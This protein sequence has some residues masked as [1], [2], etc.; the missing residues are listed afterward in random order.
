MKLK[1]DLSKLKNF[2]LSFKSIKLSKLFKSFKSSKSFKSLKSSKR[3]SSFLQKVKKV[4]PSKSPKLTLSKRDFILVSLLV[5]GLEG[6]ELYNMLLSPKWQAYSS[7]QTRYAGEQIIATNFG[8]DMANKNQYLEND[9][10]LDYKLSVLKQEIPTEIPQ[11]E[12][13]L[14][15]NKLAKA[16]KLDIGGIA[17]SSIST[18]S[19]QDFAAGKTSSAQPQNAGNK[20]NTPATVLKDTETSQGATS[21]STA[22]DSKTSRARPNVAGNVLLV[23]DVD[24]TFSGN[25]GTLYNFIGE[26]EKSDRRVIVK[27]V[28]MVRGDGSLLK[29]A[30]KIQYVG[31]ITSDDKST[32]SLDT[33]PVNGKD[34]PFLAYPGFVDKVAASNVSSPGSA[35]ASD[36]SLGSVAPVKT[37]NP[38]FYLL[39]N[40]YDDNA[41]K[42]IMGDYTKDG[43]E[44]YNNSNASVRGKLSISGNQDSMTYSYSLGGTPQTRTGKLLL[45]GGKLRV[46]V[47]SQAR[48]NG[49]D[50]VSLILD[51]DNQTNYPLEIDVIKDDKQAPRFSLGTQSGSVTVK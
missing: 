27:E 51:V 10:L 7:L 21:T 18:V 32:Y 8:K 42:M 4:K 45:D 16:S 50:K 5:L 15:L 3:I 30:L 48:K 22:N 38:N 25:Y 37:Y 9:K 33:P 44:I 34:S 31:Y 47:I 36:A 12:I 40:S 19:K 28:S 11:E 46:Q 1:V 6:Y 24:I 29:G 26:L 23:E 2:D 35:S 17:L 13:V 14:S 49:Q 39:L 20:V 43:T 41:P